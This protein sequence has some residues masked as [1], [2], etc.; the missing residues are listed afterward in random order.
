M[1]TTTAP[2]ADLDELLGLNRDY[3]RSVQ[4]SD[5]R[6][7]DEIL[8]DDFLCTNPDRSLVDRSAFLKQP[9]ATAGVRLPEV[10]LPDEHHLLLRRMRFHYLDWG[11]SGLLPVLFLHGGGLNAHTWDL[12]CAALRRERHCLALDQRGHGESEWSPQM[13]Y[14]IESH[15]GDL[16]AFV[17]ALG[18]ERFVLVGMSL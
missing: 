16:D 1:Q 7:F 5:V 6:R 13:D 10:V 9:A 18:L 12:V 8:A 14:A 17:H 4:H 3:I 15:V 11:T 2:K